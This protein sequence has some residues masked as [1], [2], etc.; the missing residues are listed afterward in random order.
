MQYSTL[1]EV[2]V[3]VGVELGNMWLQVVQNSYI[4]NHNGL[5]VNKT[6]SNWKKY[7]YLPTVWT[8]VKTFVLFF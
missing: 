6:I 7:G 3:E 5:N 4:C 1:V 8:N 2:E